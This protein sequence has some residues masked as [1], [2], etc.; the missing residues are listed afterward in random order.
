LRSEHT[1]TLE[2]RN[3][4]AAHF[5]LNG[6]QLTTVAVPEPSGLALIVLG[7]A[8]LLTCAGG[9]KWQLLSK[10]HRG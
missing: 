7:L 6:F 1:V 4:T 10:S 3:P 5:G 9:R 2:F 8:G